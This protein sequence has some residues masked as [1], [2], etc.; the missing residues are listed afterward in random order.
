MRCKTA[1]PMQ[2]AVAAACVLYGLHELSGRHGRAAIAHA[3][4]Y[5]MAASHSFD[6]TLGVPIAKARTCCSVHAAC[7]CTYAH[8]R[9]TL[10]GGPD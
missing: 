8:A 6:V 10:Y 1:M 3:S 7:R 9:L 5:A 4:A 2:A